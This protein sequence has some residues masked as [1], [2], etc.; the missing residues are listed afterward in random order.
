M[1]AS[2]WG[3]LPQRFQLVPF[4]DRPGQRGRL[5]RAA[6]CT[7]AADRAAPTEF[8]GSNPGSRSAF[9][10]GSGSAGEAAVL[11]HPVCRIDALVRHAFERNRSQHA[12]T[13][14]TAPLLRPL[15]LSLSKERRTGLGL[16]SP[17]PGPATFPRESARYV[18][19]LVQYVK[20]KLA[21]DCPCR[22]FPPHLCW[23]GNLP[24]QHHY[25]RPLRASQ[26]RATSEQQLVVCSHRPRIPADIG[27]V[28]AQDNSASASYAA[29]IA[30]RGPCFLLSLKPPPAAPAA[31]P[32]ETAPPPARARA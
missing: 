25:R 8:P 12:P 23:G 26:H 3:A 30:Q 29:L 13:S 11:S 9:W 1:S 31:A 17:C 4:G 10:A 6:C 20:R 15:I 2:G 7:R 27:M 21:G 24:L 18:T 19:Y 16:A 32:A 22:T 28:S 14:P 5:A